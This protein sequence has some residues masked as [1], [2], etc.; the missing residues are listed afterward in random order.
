MTDIGF[1]ITKTVAVRKEYRFQRLKT[2]ARQH[3]SAGSPP[4]G[5]ITLPFLCYQPALRFGLAFQIG[6]K[7]EVR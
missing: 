1:S 3:G 7:K 6:D 4:T 2:S 5:P